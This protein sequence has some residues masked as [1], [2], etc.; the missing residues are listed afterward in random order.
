MKI[1]SL[2]LFLFCMHLNAQDTIKTV[3][4]SPPI[5]VELLI[6]NNRLGFQMSISKPFAPKSKFGY[7]F[8]TTLANDYKTGMDAKKNMNMVTLISARYMLAKGLHANAGYGIN[9]SWGVRPFIGLIYVKVKGAFVFATIPSVYFSDSQYYE[10]MALI[11]YKPTIKNNWKLYT[12]LQ[13]LYS[14]DFKNDEHDRSFVYARLGS[15]YKDLSFGFGYNSDVYA[16][17][18]RVKN[19]TGLFLRVTAF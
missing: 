9:P 2:F 7:V 3:R 15:T 18:K 1:S 14:Y 4:P 10:M 13:G 16:P 17:I 8:I 19:N 12:K 6:G 11:E 5:P